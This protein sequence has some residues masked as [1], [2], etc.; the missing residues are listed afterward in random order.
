MVDKVVGVRVSSAIGCGVDTPAA[1]LQ[2]PEAP[3]SEWQRICYI[4]QCI[5][6]VRPYQIAPLSLVQR[7]TTSAGWLHC[8]VH[9]PAVHLSMN[10]VERIDERSQT[11]TVW[12]FAKHAH[13]TRPSVYIAGALPLVPAAQTLSC[14]LS[15]F[16]FW[17]LNAKRPALHTT[18]CPSVVFATLTEP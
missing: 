9:H 5:S 6:H 14:L 10:I 7:F 12:S 18:G 16:S 8:A 17:L 11:L 13:L 3:C 2:E 4:S 1:R 15:P